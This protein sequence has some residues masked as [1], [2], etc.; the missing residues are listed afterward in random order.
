MDEL[1]RSHLVDGEIIYTC[2]QTYSSHKKLLWLR[3]TRSKLKVHSEFRTKHWRGIMLYMHAHVS[4]GEEALSAEE[5]RLFKSKTHI[6]RSLW[7]KQRAFHV[8]ILIPWLKSCQGVRVCHLARCKLTRWWSL[9]SRAV[10]SPEVAKHSAD[11]WGLPAMLL[12]CHH[13]SVLL[14]RIGWF[15]IFRRLITISLCP[16]MAGGD[17]VKRNCHCWRQNVPNPDTKPP[18]V[19]I[20]ILLPA[21]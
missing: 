19:Y 5:L 6:N 9:Q 15:N 11:L 3:N 8:D 16:I 4:S 20:W 10:D 12:P 1:I 2:M 21:C 17:E 14:R 13:R 18:K 7:H